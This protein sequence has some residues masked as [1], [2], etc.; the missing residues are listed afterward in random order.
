MKTVVYAGVPA[1][2]SITLTINA[3][4]GLTTEQKEKPGSG[5]I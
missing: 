5:R 3:G 1:G 2:G 4:I